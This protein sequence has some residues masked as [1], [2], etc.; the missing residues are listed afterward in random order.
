M[1]TDF[2]VKECEF[3]QLLSES[4]LFIKRSG[5]KFVLAA[6]YVDDVIIAHNCD[7]MFQS[8]RSKLTSR[9]KCKDLDTLIRA[10]NMEIVR[11]AHGGVFLSQSA[12]IKDI[13]E[14]FKEHVPLTANASELPADPKTRLYSG[15]SKQVRG[16]TPTGEYN[17]EEGSR[18]CTATVPYRELLGKLLWV[19]QGTRPDITYAVSQCAEFSC[20]PKNAHW[21]AL[22]KI[23]RYLKGTIDYGI[24]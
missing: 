14:R 9:F 23:L 17:S 10:L 3:T 1:L 24:Y 2:M 4:C 15:G 5:D 11:T 6:I 20:N 22:K 21:W 7:S 16:Y 13:L 18:D 8:F 12:Y 19:S